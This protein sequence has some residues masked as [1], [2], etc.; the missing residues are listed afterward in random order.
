MAHIFHIWLHL[1]VRQRKKLCKVADTLKLLA[2]PLG[3]AWMIYGYLKVTLFSQFTFLSQR[4]LEQ[5]SL[6][7]GLKYLYVSSE[8][9]ITIK[10]IA[11]RK[12][13]ELRLKRLWLT[14]T[15]TEIWY[16]RVQ[17]DITYNV[18]LKWKCSLKMAYSCVVSAVAP[19]IFMHIWIA[20]C[21][22]IETVT[23]LPAKVIFSAQ[24]KPS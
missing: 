19:C 16:K 24:T 10:S 9:D 12:R 2:C 20:F 4:F 5:C 21:I 22:V 8:S 18:L 13:T 11:D 17:P 14:I 6:V 1:L 23:K 7:G 15:A 3:T